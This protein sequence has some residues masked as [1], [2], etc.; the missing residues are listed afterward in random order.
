M[1]T[2]LTPEQVAFV[3]QAVA[4]GQYASVA[5][6][7][8]Q[9]WAIGIKEV[10]INI[11]RETELK[12]L[13]DIRE[14]DIV[15]ILQVEDANAIEEQAVEFGEKMAEVRRRSKYLRECFGELIE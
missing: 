2:E 12:R 11:V 13:R 1:N 6:V 4:S 9:V 15:R 7:I 14:Q 3:E 10:E 8:A 5:E